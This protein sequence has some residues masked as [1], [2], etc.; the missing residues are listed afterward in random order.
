MFGP[1]G[2]RP[3]DIWGRPGASE[4]GP[5]AGLAPGPR[6]R[7]G[8][9]YGRF[10]HGPKIIDFYILEYVKIDHAGKRHFLDHRHA[11]TGTRSQG[12]QKEKLKKNAGT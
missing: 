1:Y 12:G 8:S 4:Q 11:T 9:K 10:T 5:R 2:N 3:Y 7:A 6:L